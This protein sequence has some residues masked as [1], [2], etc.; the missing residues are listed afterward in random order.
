MVQTTEQAPADQ[1]VAQ[2]MAADRASLSLECRA[3]AARLERL[4]APDFHATRHS[5]DPVKR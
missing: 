4:L 5:V 2:A 1:Q 3:D